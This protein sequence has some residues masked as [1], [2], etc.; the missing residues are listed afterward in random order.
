M[1]VNDKVVN[2]R[3]SYFK[4]IFSGDPYPFKIGSIFD[5]IKIGGTW[6]DQIKQI[7]AGN[8]ELK[9]HL[10]AAYF[11]GRFYDRT[12]DTIEH[13]NSLI[14]VDID[15]YEKNITELKGV[16]FSDEHCVAVF[17]SPSGN[18][19]KALYKLSSGAGQHRTDGFEYIRD[20]IKKKYKCDIDTACRNINRFCFMSYD[21]DI[22]F[23]NDFKTLQVPEN[24]S[25]VNRQKEVDHSKFE[26]SYSSEHIFS[27]IVEWNNRRHRFAKG[28][29]NN[30]IF[31]LICDGNR[32]GIPQDTLYHQIRS[33][34]PSY[35]EKE[36][37][38]SLKSHYS[39]Y[40]HEHGIREMIIRKKKNDGLFD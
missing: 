35:S 26:V 20:W 36:L 38:T 7:R 4:S 32:Y 17:L 8:Q 28:N 19:I 18:G 14:M 34:Y 13:Y 1:N 3:I 31:Q 6:I 16:L 40:T 33:R 11:S 2:E 5:N 29:R 22:M 27:Q 12:L 9:Q 10:P 37:L 39:R 25:R 23:R 21:P 30:F 15:K 24:Y